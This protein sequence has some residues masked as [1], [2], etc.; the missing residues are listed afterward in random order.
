MTRNDTPSPGGRT[1]LRGSGSKGQ[2]VLM[3]NSLYVKQ[4]RPFREGRTV[5]GRGLDGVGSV[6]GRQ[7][8]F[9][10]SQGP[11]CFSRHLDWTGTEGFSFFAI[12]EWRVSNHVERTW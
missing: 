6:D 4:A 1:G 7:G 10:R 5:A 11:P 2:R 9:R 12:P 8:R 3:V